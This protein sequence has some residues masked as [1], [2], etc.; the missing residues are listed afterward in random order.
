MLP[1]SGSLIQLGEHYR[2]KKLVGCVR[3][4]N[5]GQEAVLDGFVVRLGSDGHKSSCSVQNKY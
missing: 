3:A 1:V 5:R 2:I 4:G